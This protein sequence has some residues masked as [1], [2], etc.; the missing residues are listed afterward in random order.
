MAKRIIAIV[1]R[2]RG[3]CPTCKRLTTIT[4]TNT[5]DGWESWKCEENGCVN[6]YQI[7]G[8]VN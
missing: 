4:I 5:G 1:K 6:E 7:Y 3:T 2:K 8:R